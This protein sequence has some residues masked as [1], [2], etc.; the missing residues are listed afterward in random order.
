MIIG[1]SPPGGVIGEKGFKKIK[2]LKYVIGSGDLA[3]LRDIERLLNSDGTVS[4]IR[5]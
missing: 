5:D 2:I 1:A 3:I 4:V